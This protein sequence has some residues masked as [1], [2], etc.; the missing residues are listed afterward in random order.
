MWFEIK[1]KLLF[2]YFSFNLMT[3]LHKP[4]FFN[5]SN[6][7]DFFSS[8]LGV[9][10]NFYPAHWNNVSLHEQI[11]CPNS[12]SKCQLAFSGP[13][14][15]LKRPICI[16]Y[17]TKCCKFMY[18]FFEQVR[19]NW[20]LKHLPKILQFWKKRKTKFDFKLWSISQ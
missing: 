9:L 5:S 14:H 3:R 12:N 1:R 19:V 15:T 2:K 10:N 6:N 11:Y 17:F 4:F 8:K 7:I 16:I 20:N 18:I 13:N